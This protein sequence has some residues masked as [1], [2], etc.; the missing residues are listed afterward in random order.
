ML[1]QCKAGHM[2]MTC[3]VLLYT[4]MEKI[5][6]AVAELRE[7]DDLAALESPVHSLHPLAKLLTTFIYIFVTV[8]FDKYDLSGLI[9]MLVYPVLMF[10][11]SGIKMSTC[12]YKLRI[13]LPLV[14]AVGLFN[15]F[16]DKAPMLSIGA[17]TVSGGVISMI[18]L[19]MK[20]V[21][22]LMASFIFVSTTSLDAICAALRKIHI[23]SVIVTL[24]LLT[25]RYVTVMME[26]VSVMTT[27]YML[28]APGQKGIN[29]KAWGSFLGQLLLRSMDR[30]E[31][32]Y[33]SMLLRGFNGEFSY[34]DVPKGR[35]ADWLFTIAASV[36]FFVFR[37]VNVAELLGNIIMRG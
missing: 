21:F 16:F 3:F 2:I 6:A 20:G 31:E 24:L 23:P 5:D 12:F 18:T 11:A 19:M 37:Y 32:L 14:C 4:G 28:R 1:F 8:S 36:L 22:S 33:S 30:S 34:A 25:F 26:E 35:L 27:A 15:P 13:V 9:V 7:M 29:Y 10:Q 17:L